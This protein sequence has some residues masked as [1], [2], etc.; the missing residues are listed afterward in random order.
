MA[1]IG[2]IFIM[3]CRGFAFVEFVSI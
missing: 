3:I 2:I 1:S